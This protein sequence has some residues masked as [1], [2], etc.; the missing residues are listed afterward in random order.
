MAT[1]IAFSCVST[2]EHMA[3]SAIPGKLT[4]PLQNGLYQPQSTL[5]GPRLLTDKSRLKEIYRLRVNVWEHSGKSKFVNRQLFP[6]GWFD[7]LDET[8]L[9]WTIMND[10]NEIVA[11]ARLNVFHS[12]YEFPYH[13]SMKHLVLPVAFPF[14]FYSR[15]VVDHRYHGNGLSRQLAKSRMSF[16]EKNSINWC[17]VFINNTHIL[18][19]FE[20]L[21]FK[22]TGQAYVSYHPSLQPHSVNVLIKN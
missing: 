10:Q 13:Q 19:L 11:A 21:N 7:E 22:N 18:K 3:A 14:A 12:L 4:H 6:N 9:H 16:C 8:A 15:L 2:D 17:M 1:N 5:S 20:K